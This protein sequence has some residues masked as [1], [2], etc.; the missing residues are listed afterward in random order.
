MKL[1]DVIRNTLCETP[2]ELAALDEI[3]KAKQ[4]ELVALQKERAAKQKSEQVQQVQA[5]Q[6]TQQTQQA[7]QQ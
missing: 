4:A 1:R 2:E 6:Q 3:I 7:Q 5:V